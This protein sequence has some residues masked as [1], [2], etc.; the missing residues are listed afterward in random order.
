MAEYMEKEATIKDLELLANYQYGARQ[1]GIL[2]VCE[3]LKRKP[4]ADVVSRV[5]FEQIMWERDQALHQL[6][7]HGLTLGCKADVV[8]VVR[9]RECIHDG[10]TSCPL[11]Y[12]EKHTLCFVN[13]DAEFYCGNGERG[14]E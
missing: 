7:E 5:A 14:A 2:G 8:E 6:E 11:C 1:Q 9:C 3:T 12:I 4:A 13:H 10:L